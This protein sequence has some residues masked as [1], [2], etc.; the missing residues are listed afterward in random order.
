MTFRESVM[1]KKP[2]GRLAGNHLVDLLG[3]EI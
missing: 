2:G 1:M 3:T